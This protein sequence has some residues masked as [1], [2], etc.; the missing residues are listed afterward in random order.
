MLRALV[1]CVLLSV[2]VQAR[3]I[4]VHLPMNNAT[5][6]GTSYEVP[7]WLGVFETNTD[8]YAQWELPLTYESGGEVYPGQFMIIRNHGPDCLRLET[9]G[10]ETINGFSGYDLGADFAVIVMSGYPDWVVVSES[11][12]YSASCGASSSSSTG[13][14]LAPRQAYK[15][16]RGSVGKLQRM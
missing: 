10:S 9:S 4:P 14:V 6:V 1:L 13:P 2:A 5:D 8:A 11:P 16:G 12:I 7:T 15:G 3:V